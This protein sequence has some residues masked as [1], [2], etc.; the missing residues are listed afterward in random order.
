MWYLR[1]TF[2]CICDTPHNIEKKHGVNMDL[3][4]ITTKCFVMLKIEAES[5]DTVHLNSYVIHFSMHILYIYIA[6]IIARLREK[7]LNLFM[8]CQQLRIVVILR[9]LR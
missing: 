5:A 4:F 8:R 1:A 2:H 6:Y 7:R 9:T 3:V